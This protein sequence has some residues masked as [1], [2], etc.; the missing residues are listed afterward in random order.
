MEEFKKIPKASN[1]EINAEAQIRNVSDKKPK[2]LSKDGKALLKKDDGGWEYFAAEDLAKELFYTLIEFGSSKEQPPIAIDYVEIS[3]VGTALVENELSKKIRDA[4][5]SNTN[6]S[7]DVD[8]VGDFKKSK[9]EKFAWAIIGKTGVGKSHKEMD[10]KR[11]KIEKV[12]KVKT[13]KKDKLKVDKDQVNHCHPFVE[14]PKISAVL[15]LKCSESIKLWKLH[16]LGCSTDE[17][18]AHLQQPPKKAHSFNSIIWRY[19]QNKK[20]R[21]RADLK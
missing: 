13:E 4:E 6:E 14:T 12:A 19:K 18:L 7:E 10:K 3:N 2:S 9:R 17:I 1:Y 5:E 11:E 8:L 15:K 21:D 20:L 16:K